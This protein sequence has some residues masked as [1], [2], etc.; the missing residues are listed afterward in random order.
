MPEHKLWS[1]DDP[2]LYRLTASLQI[3][4]STDEKS[5]CFGFRD[6][7][8]EN[9]YFRLNGKRIFLN[10]LNFSTHFPVGYTVPLN[11]DMLQRDVINMKALGFNFVRIPFGCPN[12][13]ELDIYDELGILVQMEHYGCWQMG[14]YNGYKYP[15]PDNFQDLMLLRYEHSIRDIVLRDRNHA[16][17]VMW[18]MLNE[19]YDGALFSKS[20]FFA[21]FTPDP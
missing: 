1:P 13:R 11:E 7:R 9:G 4:G 14:D 18:G 15:K 6:F 3:L 16:S 2:M 19:T 20:C 10:G 12:P 8:F 5:V 21:S 17:V